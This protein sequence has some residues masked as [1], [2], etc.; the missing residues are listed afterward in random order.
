MTL[1]RLTS[2]SLQENLTTPV[3]Y[4]VV[5]DERQLQAQHHDPFPYPPPFLVKRDEWYLPNTN[6]FI[7]V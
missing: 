3:L 2:T 1:Y 4:N 7:S 5:A 6:I